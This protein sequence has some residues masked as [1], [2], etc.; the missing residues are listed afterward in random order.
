MRLAKKPPPK[1]TQWKPGQ[2]GNKSGRPK[3]L[4]SQTDVKKLISEFS[5]KTKVELLEIKSDPK[6]NWVEST[7]ATQM[8][9]AEDGDIGALNLVFDR[10]IG[11][12]KEQKEIT[13]IPKPTIVERRDGTAMVLG[14]EL[15][16][17]ESGES[18]E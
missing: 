12:V 18:E 8:L 3:D 5:R 7:L 11:K 2:S 1:E 16:Q 15:K 10:S 17:L 13:V 6:S 9:N 14:A 4:L